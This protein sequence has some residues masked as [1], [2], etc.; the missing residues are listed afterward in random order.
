[1]KLLNDVIKIT[2]NELNSDKVI[3][4]LYKDVNFNINY[5]IFLEKGLIKCLDFEK[6]SFR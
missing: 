3:G 6:I 4:L 1:V 5:L 2:H